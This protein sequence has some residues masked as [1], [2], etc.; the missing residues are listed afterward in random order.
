MGLAICKNIIDSHG[1]K[2]GFTSDDTGR[3]TFYFTLP[4]EDEKV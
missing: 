4:V 3:T 2:I 1:G